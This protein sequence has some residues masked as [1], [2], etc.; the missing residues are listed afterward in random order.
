MQ[1]SSS[2]DTNVSSVYAGTD[3]RASAVVVTSGR[4][5]KVEV[6][7][8]RVDRQWKKKPRKGNSKGTPF[9]RSTLRIKTVRWD[10]KR[11]APGHSTSPNYRTHKQ[12]KVPPHASFRGAMGRVAK[13][14]MVGTVIHSL[15]GDVLATVEAALTTTV[16]ELKQRIEDLLPA[17][18]LVSHLV[19]QNRLL[20]DTDTLED[21]GISQG[22]ILHA[23]VDVRAKFSS[24]KRS[25][26]RPDPSGPNFG[27]EMTFEMA[28]GS[29]AALDEKFHAIRDE[30][31]KSDCGG[32]ITE[33]IESDGAHLLGRLSTDLNGA[34]DTSELTYQDALSQNPVK[35]KRIEQFLRKATSVQYFQYNAGEDDAGNEDAGIE[36]L[37]D[38]HTRLSLLSR[39]YDDPF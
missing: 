22:S 34:S 32:E 28:P 38:G 15:R 3:T 30:I 18:K 16:D 35:A 11:R 14:R 21:A 17:A 13:V 29:R 23:I 27:V 36:A 39:L 19:F 20:Q 25:W 1:P 33:I 12:A 24:S 26:E 6:N 4:N 31:V 5:C 37:I 9:G 2:L 7:R 8:R 10:K